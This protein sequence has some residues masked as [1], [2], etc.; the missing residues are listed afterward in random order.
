MHNALASCKAADGHTAASTPALKQVA[1]DYKWRLL[2]SYL[3]KSTDCRE[4]LRGQ[5]LR[6]QDDVEY[7]ASTIAMLVV[8]H[9]CNNPGE[10]TDVVS[11]AEANAIT[12]L[13][14]FVGERKR[15]AKVIFECRSKFEDT[16]GAAM[17]LSD[18][19]RKFHRRIEQFAG[20]ISSKTLE[21][22]VRCGFAAMLQNSPYVLRRLGEY[23]GLIGDAFQV[24]RNQGAPVEPI[25][26]TVP[27]K[28]LGALNKARADGVLRA[29]AG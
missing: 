21:I 16:Y 11:E 29:V 19:T 28:F 1:N 12:R 24:A 26:F 18:A 23:C 10:L 13:S 25:T 4:C 27:T 14:H 6:S 17:D 2:G 7:D 9:V 20:L 3:R 22:V 5:I 15:L 8:I